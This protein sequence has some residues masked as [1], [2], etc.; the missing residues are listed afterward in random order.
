MT[1]LMAGRNSTVLSAFTRLAVRRHSTRARLSTAVPLGTRNN[2]HQHVTSAERS[3]DLLLTILGSS[4]TKRDAKAYLDRFKPASPEAQAVQERKK[5]AFLDHLFKFP[6][7]QEDASAEIQFDTSQRIH[8]AL[9]QLRGVQKLS[10]EE[11]LGV[12]RTVV[13]L[14]QLGLVSVIVVD[15]DLDQTADILTWKQNMFTTV[16][17]VVQVIEEEGGRARP[18]WNGLFGQSHRQVNSIISP[19]LLVAPLNRGH[20]PVIAPVAYDED[21]CLHA[22]SA[23]EAMVALAKVFAPKSPSDGLS[24]LINDVSSAFLLDKIIIIDPLGGIPSEERKGRSHVFIN[25]Q[26]EYEE[27]KA[28]L[29]VDRRVKRQQNTIHLRN[30]QTVHACLAQLPSTSSALITTPSYTGAKGTAN[31][32]DPLIH[33]LLTD[34]P[35]FSSSLPVAGLRTPTTDTTIVR[36]GLPIAIHAG[37]QLSLVNGN[38]DLN[39]MIHLIEDSF[40]RKLD[41]ERYLKR[42]EGNLAAIIIAG[43]YE[44]AAIIT[45]ENA[46]KDGD[47]KIAYLDKFAVLQKSQGAGG[48]ADVMFKSMLYT[49]P[50]EIIWR[51]RKNNP[52][53]KWY[54]E[55]AKGTYKLPESN[56]CLFYTG[57]IAG[58]DRLQDYM[59]VAR[60]VEGSWA[61]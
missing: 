37:P 11:L 16:D 38:I 15:A 2:H 58:V 55:R 48:V 13:K 1:G 25:L 42:V 17:R 8:V 27:I 59:N 46:L 43:D 45:W 35:S 51:S 33:N 28:Q 49:F 53:N 7:Q 47:D 20:I 36:Y 19:F 31:N 57:E 22:I 5:A 6:D 52:V 18:L 60:E 32:P 54:F 21:S 40:R 34:K 4:P 41:V 50:D 30:L 61:D 14:E 26:Q 39:R 24:N 56:W 12:A 3:R 10:E 9:V 29:M 44:G 23:D